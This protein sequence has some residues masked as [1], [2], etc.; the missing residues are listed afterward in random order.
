[1]KYAITK[2]LVTKARYATDGKDHR[3]TLYFAGRD[4]IGGIGCDN[5]NDRKHARLFDDD[6]TAERYARSLGGKVVEIN[7]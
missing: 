7:E 1:M 3:R 5:W 2:V 4:S 6:R